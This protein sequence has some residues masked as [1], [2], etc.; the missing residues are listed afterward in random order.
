MNEV[1]KDKSVKA[2]ILE[3][4][5]YGII[6][7]R[8][9]NGARQTLISWLRKGRLVL[10]KRPHNDWRVVNDVEIAEIIKEFSPNGSGHWH[11]KEG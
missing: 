4:Q 1:L 5:R 10:R 6:T 9:Y 7:A 8:T 11:Y 3:M 2:L